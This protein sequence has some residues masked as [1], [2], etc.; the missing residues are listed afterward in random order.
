VCRRGEP[1]QGAVALGSVTLY[2]GA[3]CHLCERARAELE[4][5]GAE[6]GFEFAEVDIAGR[7]ELERAYRPWIP[8]LEVDG[9]R[10][11]VYRLDEGALRKRL[12]RAGGISEL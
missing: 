1:D 12:G 9:E 8:V 11:S 10:V 3:G 4:R 5:L 7:P 2:V 6:L